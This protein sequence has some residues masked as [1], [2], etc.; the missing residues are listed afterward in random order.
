MEGL[1]TQEEYS[2]YVVDIR[3]QG[4]NWFHH[5]LSFPLP[6]D[7]CKAI[8]VVPFSVELGSEDASY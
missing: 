5:V 2:L 3:N 8:Q 6:D 7:V 4:S 1:L